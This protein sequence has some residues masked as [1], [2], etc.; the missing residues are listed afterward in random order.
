MAL[1]WSEAAR[2]DLGRIHQFDIR[3][4]L[5]GR[6]PS[7]HK[8]RIF[9]RAE[10]RNLHDLVTGKTSIVPGTKRANDEKRWYVVARGFVII[11]RAT[12]TRV[13]ILN[14]YHE[15]ELHPSSL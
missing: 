6:S 11:Y 5:S 12:R 10:A 4:Q 8:D 15:R 3:R 13:E 2:E 7:L 9:L 1:R 14:I